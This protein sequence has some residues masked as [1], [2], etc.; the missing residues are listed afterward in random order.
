MII[1]FND[2][3]N[4]EALY[5]EE[6]KFEYEIF[7]II[8][9]IKPNQ[10]INFKDTTYYKYVDFSSLSGDEDKEHIHYECVNYYFDK[11]F[12]N[13]AFLKIMF[14]QYKI[15]FSNEIYPYFRKMNIGI[16]NIA[17]NK[18][19]Y[20]LKLNRYGEEIEM[21]NLYF[22]IKS[23]K[24]FI[25]N[26]IYK[27]K[28]DQ[29]YNEDKINNFLKSD[30]YKSSVVYASFKTHQQLLKSLIDTDWNKKLG[31]AN[32]LIYY[33]MEIDKSLIDEQGECI[34]WYDKF[35]KY[36]NSSETI[37]NPITYIK[38]QYIQL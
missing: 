25:S 6:Y 13:D 38:K 16:K 5:T 12:D 15:F 33:I 11:L 2:Y 27:L 34:F 31:I 21:Y 8:S 37:K 20:E 24:E 36:I 18:F 9:N 26:I 19:V 28:N 29:Q 3:I 4:E 22:N 1:K 23:T 30:E 10:I 7:P 14:E 32:F 17:P 35:Y